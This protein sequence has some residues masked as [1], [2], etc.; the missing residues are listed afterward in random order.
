[1]EASIFWFQK[2]GLQMDFV[3]FL[4]PTDSGLCSECTL[5]QSSLAAG[6]RSTQGASCREEA[7]GIALWMLPAALWT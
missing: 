7:V 1:M 4:L 3:P 5:C 6:L 2:M